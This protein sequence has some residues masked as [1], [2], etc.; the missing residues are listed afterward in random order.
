M[1][2]TISIFIIAL[3]ILLLCVSAQAGG[4]AGA[5]SSDAP[6]TTTPAESPQPVIGYAEVYTGMQSEPEVPLYTFKKRGQVQIF[7]DVIDSA[8]KQ[9]GMADMSPSD[10]TAVLHYDNG[11]TKLYL[12]V[13]ESYASFMYA[14]DLGTLYK[15]EPGCAGKLCE[16]LQSGGA[17]DDSSA[18]EAQNDIVSVKVFGRGGEAPLYTF[19]EPSDTVLFYSAMKHASKIKGKASKMAPGYR[20]EVTDK[21]G[22]REVMLWLGREDAEFQY[23]DDPHIMYSVRSDDFKKLRALFDEYIAPIEELIELSRTSDIGLILKYPAPDMAVEPYEEG[24]GCWTADS[25]AALDALLASAGGKTEFILPSDENLTL[26]KAIL[27]NCSHISVSYS[28]GLTGNTIIYS[29]VNG[30][31]DIYPWE[32]GWKETKING[33]TCYKLTLKRPGGNAA[34]IYLQHEGWTIVEQIIGDAGKA[35][36]ERCLLLD[37]YSWNND[38]PPIEPGGLLIEG[39]EN[40]DKALSA[41]G[42]AAF[43]QHH[44][45]YYE[46]VYTSN[47]EDLGRF[48]SERLGY[49]EY[50]YYDG[51][52]EGLPLYRVNVEYD[53]ER[54]T[55]LLGDVKG[56][57]Y[58]SFSY[59]MGGC[60]SLHGEV[61]ITVLPEEIIDFGSMTL[62]DITYYYSITQNYKKYITHISWERDGIRFS[63]STRTSKMQPVDE[64]VIREWASHAMRVPLG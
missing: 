57:N 1:K 7:Q 12:W 62:G 28:D 58:K 50:Y 48:L 3:T 54:V 32:T 4:K 36:M 5:L 24:R 51:G 9:P 20:L 45:W 17:P 52:E 15:A 43:E 35:D 30:N 47:M 60:P 44:G 27:Y 61:N 33:Y 56:D 59:T 38:K 39:N 10:Y 40:I 11:S 13:G 29:A 53:G 19:T 21:N 25:R 16:L 6:A 37:T 26:E 2:K 63:V 64:G 23:R 46:C 41:A 8:E 42:D 22:L 14:D 49:T 55:F 34:L 31:L 18:I